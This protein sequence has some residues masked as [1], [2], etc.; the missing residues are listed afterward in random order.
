MSLKFRKKLA[1]VT[2]VTVSNVSKSN[3]ITCN[4]NR[5]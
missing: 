2:M 4:G 1:I 5:N 3:E